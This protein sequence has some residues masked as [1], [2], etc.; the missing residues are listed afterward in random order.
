MGAPKSGPKWAELVIEKAHELDMINVSSIGLRDGDG[1][2]I[3]ELPAKA[4]SIKEYL[5]VMNDTKIRMLL[6]PNERAE[7]LA[8]KLTWLRLWKGD[9]SL[10]EK[11]FFKLPLEVG[12]K[13]TAIV[14]RYYNMV[15]F[16]TTPDIEDEPTAPTQNTPDGAGSEGDEK[17]KN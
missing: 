16:E 8:L 14:N 7:K 5:G 6:D 15:K 9:Q 10:N 3:P 11:V 13:I 4:L 12:L 17:A 2:L 1:N